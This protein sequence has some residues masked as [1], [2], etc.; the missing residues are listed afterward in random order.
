MSARPATGHLPGPRLVCDLVA[1][2]S[3]ARCWRAAARRH[4]PALARPFGA[5]EAVLQGMRAMTRSRSAGRRAAGLGGCGPHRAPV[6]RRDARRQRHARRARGNLYAVA[7][8]PER[9]WPRPPAG[10]RTTPC[11]CDVA[12]R[13]EIAPSRR[14]VRRRSCLQS[15]G[16]CWPSAVTRLPDAVRGH[17]SGQE[18]PPAG[19]AETSPPAPL[20][21]PATLDAGTGAVE[22]PEAR[23]RRDAA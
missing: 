14:R 17:G 15:D 12:Q 5:E 8:S 9:C 13:A 7:F 10:S 1:F 6:G 20:D 11:A 18:A 22:G 19:P 16:Q 23:C 21:P 3:M 2:S 4:D